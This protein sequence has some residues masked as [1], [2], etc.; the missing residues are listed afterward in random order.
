MYAFGMLRSHCWTVRSFGGILCLRQDGMGSGTPLFGPSL[1]SAFEVICVTFSFPLSFSCGVFDN[2]PR[3]NM[4]FA[5][6]LTFFTRKQLVLRTNDK[7]C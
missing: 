2:Y 5:G 6:H 7:P 1:H 4:R 3:I